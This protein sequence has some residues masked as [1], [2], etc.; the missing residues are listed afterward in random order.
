MIEHDPHHHY[1]SAV[2]SPRSERLA[3]FGARD[4]GWQALGPAIACAILS[5]AVVGLRWYT[6]AR[7][8]RCLGWD[9]YVILL[10][11]ILSWT[12]T[13]LIAAA[14]AYGIGTYP[15]TSTTTTTT[16]PS[17]I[18]KTLSLITIL[19][20][21]TNNLWA[22]TVSVT[23]ASILMQYLRIFSNP[24]VRILCYL[25]LVALLPAV[26]W[27]VLGGTLLCRPVSKLW[28][29]AVQGGRCMSAEKYWLSVAGLDIGLDVL[30]L[31]LPLPGIWG[32]RLPRR[33][34]VGLVVVF[35]LGF[36]VCAVSV[37]RLL[38]VLLVS[39][40]GDLVQSGVWN[41]IWSAVEANVGIVCACLLALKPLVARWWPRLV[42]GSEGEIPEYCMRI[43]RISIGD[44][45]ACA[46]PGDE[47]TLVPDSA[48]TVKGSR[49]SQATSSFAGIE[50]AELLFAAPS[51]RTTE[52]NG[53]RRTGGSGST[54]NAPSVTSISGFALSKK[55]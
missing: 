49:S 3:H 1:P 9:D 52:A 13:A 18:Q 6:R 4:I 11:L 40:S 34:K 23:K 25:L 31:V 8:V 29:P 7:L 30:V 38:T 2:T 26:L 21:S 55:K 27:A 39:R 28:D 19:I 20:V 15:N 51:T 53:T 24:R 36:F 32:L 43:R 54:R 14:V 47:A 16:T 45:E 50:K 12:M 10:S 17:T 22:L 48:F 37:V 46:W 44:E 33:Q 42:E 35:L 5:T 41:I